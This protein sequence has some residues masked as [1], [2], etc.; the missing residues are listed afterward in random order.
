M[1]AVRLSRKYQIVIPKRIREHLKLKPGEKLQVFGY[2]NRIQF[3][4]T[5]EMRSM[6]GI[7]KGLDSA[8]QRE[9]KDPV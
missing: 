4:P 6:R 5:K 3:V 7:L 1:D 8:F 2:D 9:G